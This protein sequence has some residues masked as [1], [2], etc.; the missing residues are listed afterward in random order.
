ML[1]KSKMFSFLIG[2]N[3]FCKSIMLYN[4]NNHIHIQK[5][6]EDSYGNYYI[7][8]KTNL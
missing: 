5:D 4:I 8:Y 3:I 2:K 6:R 7:Q 1:I